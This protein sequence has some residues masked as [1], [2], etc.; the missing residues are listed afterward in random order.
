MPRSLDHRSLD[1]SIKGVL[2]LG[3]SILIKIIPCFQTIKVSVI[4]KYTSKNPLK[5]WRFFVT[6][7]VMN[8][9]LITLSADSNTLIH[10]QLFFYLQSTTLMFQYCFN[11]LFVS[12][13]RIPVSVPPR[14][15]PQVLA[16][17]EIAL[18]TAD[19]FGCSVRLSC[20]WVGLL[21]LLRGVLYSVSSLSCP[22][23]TPSSR[24]H[25]SYQCDRHLRWPL[26]SP[27]LPFK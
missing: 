24:L 17:A 19:T 13:L 26:S 11:H 9:I 18:D 20:I 22:Q 15:L 23:S 16:T 7:F 27:Q 25:F 8:N 3:R 4:S 5:N 14:N 1:I 21:L 12:Q 10:C 2:K 6:F